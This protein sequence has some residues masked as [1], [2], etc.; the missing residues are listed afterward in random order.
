MCIHFRGIPRIDK[1][2]KPQ[3]HIQKHKYSPCI[4]SIFSLTD[5]FSKVD[6]ETA[7]YKLYQNHSELSFYWFAAETFHHS[8]VIK[9]S[10]P[11]FSLK[12]FYNWIND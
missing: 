11:R 3:S 8:I 6:G 12:D 4:A 9:T 10:S 5:K 1:L 7:N 2:A